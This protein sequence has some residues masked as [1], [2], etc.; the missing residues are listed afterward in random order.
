LRQELANLGQEFLFGK[1]L[2]DAWAIRTNAAEKICMNQMPV[3]WSPF[4]PYDPCAIEF[5]YTHREWNELIAGY[6]KVR[7]E[8]F[9]NMLKQELTKPAATCLTEKSE[10]HMIVRL[11]P[12]M[13]FMTPCPMGITMGKDPW[14]YTSH[15]T[16]GK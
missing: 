7:W 4:R 1:W 10:I 11:I 8:K 2:S 5:D 14:Y 16:I 12:P 15:N 3:A 6:Y 13:Y 9:I